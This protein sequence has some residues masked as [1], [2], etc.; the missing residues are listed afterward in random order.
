MAQRNQD[1]AE[2][3]LREKRLPRRAKEVQNK[4]PAP[5]Q[6]T[7]EQILREAHEMQFEKVAAPPRQQI[8]DPE[9]LRMYKL[10][11]RKNFE[12]T[13]RRNRMVCCYVIIN[14]HNT[15]HP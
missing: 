11:K 10:R 3:G 1:M 9:E 2:T 4:A 12:N 15:T 14:Q 5:Q 6:I 7:A 8:T 13:L